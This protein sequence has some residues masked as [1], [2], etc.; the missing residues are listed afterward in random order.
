MKLMPLA[1]PVFLSTVISRA[2]A[3]VRS[4]RRPVS[5]AG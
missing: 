5:I 1:L 2:M 3:L 4:V